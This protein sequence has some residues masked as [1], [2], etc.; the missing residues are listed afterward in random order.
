MKLNYLTL[1]LIFVTV[2]I[3]CSKDDDNSPDPITKADINGSVNLYDE[4]TT[5]IDNSG[6]TI[7]VEETEFFATTNNQGVFNLSDIPF[8]TYTLVYEKQGFGTFK[9]FDIQHENDATAIPNTPSLGETSSTQVTDLT[10]QV[11]GI[12]ITFSITTN[13]GGSNSNR[14]YVRY[15]LSTDSNV[16]KDNYSFHSSGLIS[17]INPYETT[18]PLN[19]LNNAGFSTGQTVYIKA[20]GDSFWSNEYDDLDLDR[21]VFPNLNMNSA[22][23]VSFVVP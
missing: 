14:R 12:D 3:S 5:K 7:K 2:F 15:F 10:A 19:E 21:K 6:M 4:G 18:L 17:Q 9:K 20:Y 8:G 13:P 22:D 16:S 23:P 11:N 1:G